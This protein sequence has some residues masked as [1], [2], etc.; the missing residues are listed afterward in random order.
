VPALL[1]GEIDVALL[2]TSP[3]PDALEERSLFSDE[4]VFL[5]GRSHPLAR[6]KALTPSDL[7]EHALI[8]GNTP[9][10]EA[11]W[12]R[13]RVFGRRRPRLRF[14]HFSLTEAIVDATRAG[15]GIAV[16]SEWIASAYLGDHELV[17]KRLASGPLLRPWRIAFRRDAA[18]AAHQLH[19]VLSGAAPRGKM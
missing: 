12:F 11:R 15:M 16:L 10:A 2:T 4:I 3:V 9:P 8:S 7:R 13:S 19:A 1:A 18:K 5:V 17:A 6:R 14:A